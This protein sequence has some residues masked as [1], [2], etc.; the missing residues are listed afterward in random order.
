MPNLL[1]TKFYFPPVPDGFV[2]RPQL[3]EKLD[4]ALT[5]RL[6]LVS[7][8]AGSGK[9]TLVSA[10]AQSVRKKGAAFGW[11]SLDEADNDAE[12]FIEYL[13]ASLEEGGMLLDTAA[14]PP[15]QREQA[16]VEAVLQDFIRELVNLK[17]EVILI[18]DDYHLISN[19]EVHAALE[20]LLKHAPPYLH[21]VLLT[22][23]DPPLE[24]ARQRVAGQLVELR[25]EQ[26]RFTVPEAAAFLKKSAGVQLTE[27]EVNALNTRAEGWI[28][29]LQ[30]AAISLRGSENTSEFVTAFAGSHRFVFDYLLEEVLNRQAPE[31]SDFLLKTSVLERLSAPLCDAV[32]ETGNAAG[33]LLDA[34]ERAN[35]FLVPLDDERTWYRYHH[36]FAESL[37]LLLEQIHPGFSAE[38][39]RRACCW[40]E[41]QGTLPDALHHALAAGDME[42]AAR[43]ISANVLV[44][45]E[46]AELRPIL[47]QIDAIPRQQRASLPWLEVAHAWGLA[48]TGQVNR[49]DLA[50]SLAEQR[51][52]E[53]A[54]EGRNKM[55]GHIAAV[56]AYL[57]WTNG[58]QAEAVAFAE[59]AAGLLPVEEI[60]VRA[61][62]L[63]TLG[64]A[65]M[66]YAIDPRA[67]EVLE[68]ALKLAQ[69]V[70]QSHVIMATASG[71]AY[72]YIALGKFHR[73]NEVCVEAIEIADAYQRRN[74]RPLTA[75]ASAYAFWSRVWLEMGEIEKAI[76]TARKAMA[77][78]EQWGQVDTMMVCHL[79]LTIALAYGN[80]MG[81]AREVLLKAR[82][83]AQK[84][85]SPWH[86]LNVDGLELEVRI[87]AGLLNPAESRQL[88]SR[89][90]EIG[91]DLS[92]FASVRLLLKQNLFDEA[93]ATLEGA[94]QKADGYPTVH[95]VRLYTLQALAYFQKKDLPHA[96]TSLKQALALAEPENRVF[97][98][99]REGEAMEKLLRLALG[100]SI[101]P[102]FIRRLL[103]GFETRREFHPG[104]AAV[105][106]E[107]IE[108]L[109][110][111]ELEVLRYL[112]GP[113]STPEIA[114]QM[115]VSTNTVRTHIKNIYG[116]LGVHG[117]S[118]AVHQARQLGLQ[119]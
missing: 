95:D 1:P 5:H 57:T 74:A 42:L 29:G 86:L 59:K 81:S 50:L 15:R 48:Y 27:V 117:R 51:S 78:S 61:L 90:I 62:N 20:Y 98:F 82:K 105:T 3:L 108:P 97:T 12:R 6:T 72:A 24:L 23:S 103:V 37:R 4:E 28:A 102:E 43:L 31:V 58:N 93:L 92:A 10:W 99:V 52:D 66:Q 119:A 33:V 116:K 7:A 115:M 14:F 38:L 30:M 110:E 88:M 109:S 69:Q 60:A 79:Y 114:E 107:L 25:M 63:T 70:E 16:K 46:H 67:A 84:A 36:L 87:D 41:A 45:V 35:L 104:A 26:L 8:Q 13:V 47:A 75:A 21:L 113:L 22:R 73:A 17:R 101:S 54:S 89:K 71:L 11:L 68:E 111:R 2:R 118:A 53:S 64:N 18:L 77:L 76:Q 44:L 100:K 80:Q 83:I 49:A 39:H 32:A 56:R 96:L 55:L 106:E 19:K 65:L 94:M 91:L 85:S 112:N 40:H 9:T 34:I